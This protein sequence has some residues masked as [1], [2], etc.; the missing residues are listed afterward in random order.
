MDANGTVAFN[1]LQSVHEILMITLTSIK[2]MKYCNLSLETL[3]KKED[4]I[5]FCFALTKCIS[6]LNLNTEAERQK[7]LDKAPDDASKSM[8]K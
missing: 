2:A 7:R 4:K 8:W 3:L 1:E 6:K 5:L